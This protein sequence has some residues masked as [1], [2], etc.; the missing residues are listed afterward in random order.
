MSGRKARTPEAKEAFRFRRTD[1][2]GAAG[3]EEDS[4][5]LDKCFV[6]TGDSSLLLDFADNRVLVVGRT[7][8]GKSALLR[9][10]AK[11]RPEDTI[12][13]RPEALAL[14]Y[15]ANSTV[16]NFFASVGVN[17]DPFFK[18]LWR[19]V[20]TVEIL[21]RHFHRQTSGEK[22][23]FMDWLRGHFVGQ[24]REDREMRDALNYLES[25]GKSFW[26]ETEFRVREITSKVEQE[27]S[28][29][30]KLGV[31]VDVATLS[32]GVQDLSKLSTEE[33]ADLVTRGQNVISKAQV[34]DLHQVIALLDNVLDKRNRSYYVTVD[35]LD[36]NWVEDRLRYKLIMALIQTARE[37]IGVRSAKIIVALR[38]DLIDRVFRLTRDSG[39]QEEK[40]QSL[41]LPL[42][43]S[44]TEILELLDRRVQHLVARRYTKQPVTYRDLLPQSFNDT[45]IS[46]YIFCVADRPR[47]VIAFFNC[48][49]LAGTDHP[50]LSVKQ[51][52]TAGSEYS[53]NRLRALADEWSADFPF[54]ID[55]TAILNRRPACFKLSSIAP[56]ELANLC[57]E[58][59]TNNPV[60]G[61]GLLYETARAVVDCVVA[62]EDFLVTLV[63]VFYRI[64]LVGLKI[65]PTDS[66]SWA[67]DMGQAVSNSQIN[68]DTSVLVKPTYIRA[69]GINDRCFG[70]GA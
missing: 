47:D 41:Y 20:L 31:G 63:Q 56:H 23:G 30:L 1:R 35:G 3:A 48:C 67:D 44:R 28:T 17:L 29:E 45:P 26:L 59:V 62:A 24:S 54:L 60:G 42:R 22:R 51:L 7:G 33:R 6:D 66:A 61:T 2:V 50:K 10:I 46:E 18:L 9:E 12:Q 27:L 57:L 55:F 39:F 70:E 58:V 36:E 37:F 13:V 34:R 65:S 43:W 8:T 19:H 52:A 15:V 64:G 69:L 49:I 4:E 14:T 21:S 16:L 11:A 40:Y 25:W 38:R 68:G 53:R 32:G 5:F